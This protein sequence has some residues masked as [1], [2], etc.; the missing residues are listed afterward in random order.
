MR[1]TLYKAGK[2]PLRRNEKTLLHSKH[3][4]FLL[5]FILTFTAVGTYFDIV[6]EIG[7]LTSF[8]LFVTVE[9]VWDMLRIVDILL[10]RAHS[11]FVRLADGGV[12]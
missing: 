2:S 4:P 1:I 5:T 8:I 10:H 12:Q 9:R 11:L 3:I 6:A 7:S